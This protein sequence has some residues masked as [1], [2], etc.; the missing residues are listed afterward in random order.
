[1]SEVPA[2]APPQGPKETPT[3]L[4]RSTNGALA[5]VGKPADLIR[6]ALVIDFRPLRPPALSP[7]FAQMSLLERSI[8]AIEYQARVLE[9]RLG[10]NGWIRAWILVSLRILIFLIV[11]VTAFLIALGFLVPMAAGV[12]EFFLHTETAAQSALWTV[13]YGTLTLV[14]FAFGLGLL[15]VAVRHMLQR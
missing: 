1:M 9:F 14:M 8:H 2:D 4:I 3:A 11:P 12:S 7:H 13:I 15:R 6:S 5:A 10:P